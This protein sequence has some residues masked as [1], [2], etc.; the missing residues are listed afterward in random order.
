MVEVLGTSLTS[1]NTQSCGCIKSIGETNIAL[2]LSELK[3]P[4]KREY[5]I[6]DEKGKEYR[7]DFAILD[8]NNSIKSFIEY[9][10]I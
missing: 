8:K 7:F 5:R 9:D 10:G 3:I 2:L 6:F 1:G 4:F